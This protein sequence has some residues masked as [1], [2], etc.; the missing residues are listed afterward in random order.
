MDPAALGQLLPLVLFV[1][2]IWLLFVRPSRKRA[3]EIAAVQRSLQ[4]GSEIMLS[5]GIFGTIESL[6][7]DTVAVRLAP[8]TTVRVHRQAVS[9][10]IE[11]TQPADQPLDEASDESSP[12]GATAV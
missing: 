2:A 3:A 10:V 8:G 1:L 7:D 11:P 12:P 5:S 4:P 6:E 9:R